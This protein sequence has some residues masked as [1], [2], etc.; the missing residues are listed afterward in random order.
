MTDVTIAVVPRDR[1]SKTALT[2]QRLLEATP[3]PFRLIIVDAGMPTRYRRDVERAVAGRRDVEIL[4]SAEPV[5]ANAAKNWVLREV[6]DGEFLAFV[7]NDNEVHPGWLEWLIHACDEEQ[8]GVARPMIFERKVFRTFPHFDQRLGRIE[9]VEG[10]AGKSY[11]FLPRKKPLSADIGARRQT[12]SVLET[13]CLLFRRSVFHE[14]GGF[15]ER[16]STRQEVDL[17]LQ[18]WDA[19]ISIVFEPRSLVTYHRPPPVHR[20]E[21][22]YFL[23]RWSRE[24][25]EASHRIIEEKW[26]VEGIPSALEF[27][28][29]RRHY[30]TY[31]GYSLYYVRHELPIYLRYELPSNLRYAAWRLARHLPAGLGEPLR[32]ALYRQ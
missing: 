8:A 11:R 29:D 24:G 31:S 6:K 27:A 19:G 7:E 25:G 10:D 18:L 4:T 30:A 17:A 2:V 16:L 22:D 14:I 21:R 3:D 20:D 23:R 13:H 5:A 1:F 26:P 9:T 15:D 28:R 32:R 12:T